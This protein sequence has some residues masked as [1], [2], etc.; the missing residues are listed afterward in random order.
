MQPA[1]N[2]SHK[3]TYI[4]MTACTGIH[5][6]WLIA[7]NLPRET[8]LQSRSVENESLLKKKKKRSVSVIK[9]ITN[10]YNVTTCFSDYYI[11]MPRHMPVCTHPSFPPDIQTTSL[12]VSSQRHQSK[13]T[14]A[15]QIISGAVAG[16]EKM[17]KL[18]TLSTLHL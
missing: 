13:Q 3:L 17:K 16:E 8:D 7:E 1:M 11:I 6:S 9:L 15:P 14:P 5:K 10:S 12:I 18:I 2:I 4:G